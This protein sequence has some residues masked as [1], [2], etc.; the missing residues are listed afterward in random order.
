[1]AITKSLLK[2]SDEPDRRI[3]CR[4]KEMVDKGKIRSYDMW[5]NSW[6]EDFVELLDDDDINYVLSFEQRRNWNHALYH[7]CRL[8]KR[9]FYYE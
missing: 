8:S 7:Y 5:D 1:M 9:L 2:R 3:D 4:L 6:W